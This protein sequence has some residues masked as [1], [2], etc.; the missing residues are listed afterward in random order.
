MGPGSRKEFI[1]EFNKEGSPYREALCVTILGAFFDLKS[2]ELTGEA[3]AFLIRLLEKTRTGHEAARILA[4]LATE[5][6]VQ[7]TLLPKMRD[8]EG[9]LKKNLAECLSICGNRHGRR[10]IGI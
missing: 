3:I 2:D 7:S 1:D 10:Y 6:F 9:V 5:P 4:E 8:A